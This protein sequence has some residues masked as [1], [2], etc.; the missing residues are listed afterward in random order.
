MPAELPARFWS[1]V[2]ITET[3]W[4]W[5]A[6][7]K[8]KGYGQFGDGRINRAA[9]RV[10]WEAVNGP[11][12][13]GKMLLHSCDTK[14]CVNPEHLRLGNAKENARDAIAS[15][16]VP[17]GDNHYARTRP[18]LHVRGERVGNARLTAVA[19][20]EIRRLHASGVSR[21]A[22]ARKFQVGR[23]T[24]FHVIKRRTWREGA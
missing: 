11:I 2:K 21:N 17:S 9:H 15:G 6:S 10:S 12:P 5:T 18:W 22:I 3:C 24:V 19:A 14:R 13:K 23:T 4:L 20:A 1:K 7:T 8:G 16:R